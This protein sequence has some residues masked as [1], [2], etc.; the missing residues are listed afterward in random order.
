MFCFMK[1][2]NKFV[3]YINVMFIDKYVNVKVKNIVRRFLI[4]LFIR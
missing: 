2:E 1:Y 4:I 3:I